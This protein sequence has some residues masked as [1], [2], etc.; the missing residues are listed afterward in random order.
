MSR[1]RLLAL[2]GV[3]LIVLG[4]VSAVA[5]GSGPSA[6]RS[7]PWEGAGTAVRALSSGIGE[8]ESGTTG[9]YV[10]YTLVLFNNTLIPGNFL[11]WNGLQPVA[12]AYDSGK[13]E[14][15]VTNSNSVSVISDATNAVVA[16]VPVGSG[17]VAYDSG[18][19]ELFV[20]NRGSNSVSVISD[21]T[22]AVVASIPAGASPEAVA[23]DSGRGELFV[24]NEFADTVTVISDATNA[25]VATVPV[26]SSPF[27]VAYDS[28]KGEEI[29]GARGW[30]RVK[31][32]A[33]A[34]TLEEETLPVGC[35]GIGVA[36][37]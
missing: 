17:G 24:T 12:V 4:T 15:F 28:G 13:G 6:R 21:A 29:V 34:A 3:A 19:G 37:A 27:A 22:N 9:P 33:D 7:V 26:G 20:T 10:A 18:K 11:A 16:S 1:K 35:S 36:R 2:E 5:V 32:L 30:E 8:V 31:V 23:Y 25:V 14:L